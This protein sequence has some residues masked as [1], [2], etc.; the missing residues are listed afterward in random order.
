[1][2][3][4]QELRAKRRK[5]QKHRAGLTMQPYSNVSPTGLRN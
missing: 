4:I 5:N 1:M 3:Y 2:I